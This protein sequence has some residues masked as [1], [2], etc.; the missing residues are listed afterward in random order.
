MATRSTIAI[1]TADGK[2][3]SIYCHWDGY[4]ENNGKLLLTHYQ[5]REKVESLIELGAIS[6]LAPEVNPTHAHSYENPQDGIVVAYHRDRGEDYRKPDSHRSIDSF[7][8]SDVEEYGYVFT[9]AGEWLFINGH[10]EGEG[11]TP[12]PLTEVVK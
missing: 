7:S 11:R 2:V 9:K 8:K 5:N 3:K 4:P 12:I 10:K 1:E 6:Y